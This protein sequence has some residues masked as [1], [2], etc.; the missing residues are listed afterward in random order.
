MLQD[1]LAFARVTSGAGALV[2][3]DMNTVLA[4]V[5]QDLHAQTQ[6]TGAAISVGGLP[7]VRGDASQ[8]RQVFQNL[9]GNALKFRDPQRPSIIRVEAVLDGANV[10]FSVRNNGIGIEPE[11]FGRIFTIFQR[12]HGREEY[13]GNGIGLSITRKIAGRHGGEVWLDSTPGAGSTFLTLP[14]G[15]VSADSALV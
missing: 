13:E 4:Q 7:R 15:E 2:A 1:L 3:V 11:F 9:I 8:L 6:Q 5:V 10:R 14:A 12:L